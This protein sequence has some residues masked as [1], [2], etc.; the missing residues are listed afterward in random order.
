MAKRVE[1][2]DEIKVEILKRH[3]AGQ[4][5]T[6]IKKETGVEN[7]QQI[8]GVLRS[9]YTPTGQYLLKKAGLVDAEGK[10][11]PTLPPRK[12]RKEDEGSQAD[13]AIEEA[14]IRAQLA[15]LPGREPLLTAPGQMTGPGQVYDPATSLMTGGSHQPQSLRRTQEAVTHTLPSFVGFRRDGTGDKYNVYRLEPYQAFVGSTYGS[16]EEIGGKCGGGKFR[17]ERWVPGRPQPEVQEITLDLAIFGPPKVPEGMNMTP[18]APGVTVQQVPVPQQTDPAQAVKAAA[19][20]IQIGAQLAAPKPAEQTAAS[21]AGEKLIEKALEQVVNPPIA[22]KPQGFTLEDWIRIREQER[23]DEQTRRDDERRQREADDKRRRDD[24]EIA[25]KHRLEEERQKHDL[26]MQKIKAEYELKLKAQE[27]EAKAREEA[28]K[29]HEKSLAELSTEKT[30]WAMKQATDAAAELTAA[31][32][33]NQT[34]LATEVEKLNKTAEESRKRDIAEVAAERKHN[35]E[36]IGR[37]KEILTEQKK[38]NE[39][40]LKIQKAQATANDDKLIALGE[41]LLTEA[42]SRLK[43]WFGVKQAEAALQ[44]N[45]N[46]LNNAVDQNPGLVKQLASKA[47]PSGD[48]DMTKRIDQIA[49]S[50]EFKDFMEEWCL[51]VEDKQPAENLF[52]SVQR[53]YQQGD[54]AVGELVDFMSGRRWQKAKAMIWQ[55]IEENQQKI[56]SGDYATLY[57]E[58]MRTLV[59]LMKTSAMKYWAKLEMER[60]AKLDQGGNGEELPSGPD[61]GTPQPAPEP[62]PAEAKKEESANKP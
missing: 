59:N 7:G 16:H 23:K 57:Y 44:N 26:E 36:L 45:P 20:A 41:K 22:P 21:K 24:E 6:E 10:P 62:A 25:H 51:H 60:A 28:L 58:R 48:K 50:Q 5:L 55:H 19:E 35:E 18:M 46:L 13:A 3:A 43:E 49:G 33:E 1:L 42:S 52:D 8:S 61:D 14:Q 37:D 54:Q 34:K 9:Q 4:S 27:A 30:K 32:A 11:K 47:S 40:L 2:T 12:P 56:L 39:E 31:L 29:E 15:P 53:R 17:V 38:F